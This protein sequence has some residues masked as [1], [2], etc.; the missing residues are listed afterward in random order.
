[1]AQRAFI[2]PPSIVNQGQRTYVKNKEI[3]IMKPTLFT[4]ASVDIASALFKNLNGL[5]F[6]S[7]VLLW[8]LKATGN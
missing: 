7:I 1:V 2:A 4:A 6:V 5:M 3:S 8:V